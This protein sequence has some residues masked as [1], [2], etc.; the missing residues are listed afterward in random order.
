MHCAEGKDRTGIVIALAL[1]IAGVEHHQ[2][3]EDYAASAGHLASRY[4]A[5]LTAEADPDARR[6]MQRG[7]ATDSTTMLTFLDH[8]ES[9]YGGADSYLGTHGVE[10][11]ELAALRARLVTSA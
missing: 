7:Q 2:I 10:D 6:I 8:L 11:A 9:Q 1:A 4:A 5:A 3:A